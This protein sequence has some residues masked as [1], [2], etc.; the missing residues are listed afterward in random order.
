MRDNGIRARRVKKSKVTTD[1]HTG[2]AVAEN[3]LDGSSRSM[4]QT[5]PGCR[6]SHTCGPMKDG[7]TLR[8][9]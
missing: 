7:C 6:I 2:E 1:S 4:S 9:F 3:V 5:R 8:S